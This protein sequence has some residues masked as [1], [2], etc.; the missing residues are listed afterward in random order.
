MSESFNPRDMLA[1]KQSFKNIEPIIDILSDMNSKYLKDIYKKIDPLNDLM[2]AI[3]TSIN[4]NAG[5]SIRDGGIIKSGYNSQVD[6]CREASINGKDWIL[7]LESDQKKSTGIKNLRIKYSKN[8]GYC[9]ELSRS[10]ADL[11]PENYI[12]RQT[13]TNAERYTFEELKIIEDKILGAEE[14]LYKLELD[15]FLEVKSKIFNNIS[16]ILETAKLLAEIDFIQSLAHVSNIN[17]YVRPELVSDGSLI[18][19]NGRHPVVEKMLKKNQFIA[20]DV[21]LDMKKERFAIITGPNMSGKSTYMRQ[22]ALICIMAQIGS[23]V[24]C[25]SCTMDIVDKVFTRVGASDDLASG[26]STFM[27]EMTEV[28]NILRNATPKSLIILDEIGRGTSTFDG[29]SLAWAIVEYIADKN[30][31]GAKTIFATHY[32]ELTELEGKV[33]NV[34]NYYIDVY[35]KND[36]VVFLRKILRGGAN[37]SYGIQVAKLAR[38]LIKLFREQKSLQLNLKELI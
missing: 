7:K 25:K 32:H 18:I 16:R 14:K 4:E 19:K 21:Y 2:Q 20:N 31:I 10:Q 23:F 26:Q 33:E 34:V 29:L 27:V 37:K 5:F 12:R 35:E 38:S 13:L 11:V 3:E 15:L 36:N 1:L 30:Q 28:S 24:P 17:G 8:F 22:T 6:E 9:V